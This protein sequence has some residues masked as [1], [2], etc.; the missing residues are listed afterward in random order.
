MEKEKQQAHHST[1]GGTHL[2]P[3]GTWH[4]SSI[5]GPGRPRQEDH[6]VKA[7]LGYIERPWGGGRKEGRENE[8]RKGGREREDR[9]S[10]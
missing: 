2:H 4:T 5:L 10:R 3:T 9:E 8:R 7:S 6:L 1:H